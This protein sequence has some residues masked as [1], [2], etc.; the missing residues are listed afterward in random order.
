[1]MVMEEGLRSVF[2]GNSHYV[3]LLL[4]L[5]I[6]AC[7]ELRLSNCFLLFLHQNST[8][9]LFSFLNWQL[10]FVLHRDWL[11]L[12]VL[13]SSVYYFCYLFSACYFILL[14]WQMSFTLETLF[15]TRFTGFWCWWWPPATSTKTDHQ[16]IRGR[17]YAMS[18]CMHISSRMIVFCTASLLFLWL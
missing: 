1:M 3:L 10:F 11:L 18:T 16:I 17:E 7:G 5:L 6:L 14:S 15:S 13:S 9:F 2:L 8:R 12:P 4:L